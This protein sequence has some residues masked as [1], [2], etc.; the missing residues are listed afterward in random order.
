MP[1]L[2]ALRHALSVRNPAAERVVGVA[3]GTLEGDVR[4]WATASGLA[5]V[6]PLGG[7]PAPSLWDRD[8][9]RVLE[10]ATLTQ[11]RELALELDAL[12]PERAAVDEGLARSSRA[13]ERRPYER[14]RDELEGRRLAL[15]RARREASAALTRAIHESLVIHTRRGPTSLSA[16]F[17]AA[18]GGQEM[19]TGTGECAAPRLLSAMNAAGAE[20]LALAEATWPTG[21]TDPLEAL[22]AP[23][24]ERCAPILGSLL[25]RC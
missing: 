16:L 15:V 9:T 5:D 25:C 10:D 4:V 14:R 12:L 22:V 20:P 17:R 6:P 21:R 18:T 11:L 24:A 13:T 8:A 2:P 1:A 23:C 7:I 3:L 19:P